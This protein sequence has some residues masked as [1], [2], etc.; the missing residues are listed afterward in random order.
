MPSPF[1]RDIAKKAA[2]G[3]PSSF[4]GIGYRRATPVIGLAPG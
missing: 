4:T 3:P 1:R 2:S